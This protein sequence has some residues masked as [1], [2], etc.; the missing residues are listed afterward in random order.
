[1]DAFVDAMGVA[2]DSKDLVVDTIKSG[3]MNYAT[4]STINS[5]FGAYSSG[6]VMVQIKAD[7]TLVM[8]DLTK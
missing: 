6:G 8:P 4:D 5:L 2:A 1:M 7:G 3:N